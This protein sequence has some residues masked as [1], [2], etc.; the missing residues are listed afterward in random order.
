[1]T[2][3]HSA[4]EPGEGGG[5]KDVPDHSVRL[6]LVETTLWSTGYDTAG[7]LTSML[8]KRET[9]ADLLC[10]VDRGVMRKYT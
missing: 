8:E 7:I 6:A 4:D 1:M 9:L 3:T 2:D 10:D 5:V